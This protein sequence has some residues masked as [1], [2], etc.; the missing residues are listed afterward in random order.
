MIKL[1]VTTNNGLYPLGHAQALAT[2]SRNISVR[3]NQ[4]AGSASVTPPSQPNS[5]PSVQFP[6]ANVYQKSDL[7]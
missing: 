7:R 6:A 1:C 3:W 2:V 5:Q 4:G